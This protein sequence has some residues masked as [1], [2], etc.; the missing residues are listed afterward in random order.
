MTHSRQWW[1]FAAQVLFANELRALLL[2]GNHLHLGFCQMQFTP[3]IPHFAHAL[4]FCLNA[5]A[6]NNI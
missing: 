3:L 5:R 2:I 6:E 1:F 4:L